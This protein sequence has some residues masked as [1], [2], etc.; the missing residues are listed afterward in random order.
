MEAAEHL[1][2]G[3]IVPEI[4]GLVGL[5]TR[6][7]TLSAREQDRSAVEGRELMSVNEVWRWRACCRDS[8]LVPALVDGG[9][10][11]GLILRACSN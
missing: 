1:S 5:F 4:P 10:W 7:V 3:Y 8:Y 2:G 9:R 6:G 11:D